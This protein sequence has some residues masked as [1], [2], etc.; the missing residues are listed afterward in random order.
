MTYLPKAYKC[1]SMWG[2]EVGSADYY[3]SNQQTK[4]SQEDAPITA[5]YKDRKGVWILAEQIENVEI[6]NEIFNKLALLAA[7]S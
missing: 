2:H 7:R 1:V 5:I 4:A 3:I 6:R